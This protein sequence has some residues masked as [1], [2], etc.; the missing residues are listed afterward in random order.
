[1]NYTDMLTA[2]RAFYLD[3][4]AWA[5]LD[6]ARWARWVVPC[7][8]GPGETS[9]KK[10]GRRRKA[11][12]DQR[13]RERLPRLPELVRIAE[14]RA[15]DARMLLE[16]AVA[17]SPGSKFTVLGKTYTKSDPWLKASADGIPVIY[18]SRDEPSGSEKPRTEHSGLW[19]LWKSCDTQAFESK[20]CSKSAITASPN[21]DYP[22]PESSSRYCR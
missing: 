3:L 5:A 4:A 7:P 11:R 10:I 6:P 13:T 19:Q 8:I 9:A 12:M 1:M 21:I 20:R 17:A 18:D 2:V 16:A 22:P 14:Q 15:H